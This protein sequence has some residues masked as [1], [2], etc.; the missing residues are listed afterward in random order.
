MSDYLNYINMKL[1]KKNKAN[2]Y[3]KRLIGGKYV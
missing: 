1:K 2:N 3:R